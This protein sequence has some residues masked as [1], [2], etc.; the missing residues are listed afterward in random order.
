MRSRSTWI[1]LIP[2]LLLAL[3]V[4]HPAAADEALLGGWV[5]MDVGGQEP[6]DGQA[7]RF[8]FDG[9]TLTVTVE[10]SGASITWALGYTVADGVLTIEPGTGL[11]SPDAVTYTYKFEDGALVLETD[12][13][14]AA[15]TFRRIAGE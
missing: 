7:I 11:G 3:C 10:A 9:D 13:L 1:A 14:G 15:M 8:A 5:L 4:A 12:R 2:A 6:E